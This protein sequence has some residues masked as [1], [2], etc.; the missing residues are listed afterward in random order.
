M[1]LTIGTHGLGSAGYGQ[2]FPEVA[3]DHSGTILAIS[4]TIGSVPGIIGVAVSGA[5]LN[6]TNSWNVVFYFCI[7]FNIVGILAFDI[8][9]STKQII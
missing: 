8:G 5:I 2:N 1:I 4:N 6:A 7:A 9:A 3:P